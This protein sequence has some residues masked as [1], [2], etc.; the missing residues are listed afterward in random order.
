MTSKE[1]LKISLAHEE[2]DRVPVDLWLTPEVEKRLML[3]TGINDPFE[4]R[5]ALGHDCLITFVGIVASFY[6]SDAKEYV[7][8]WGITWAQASY[9]NGAGSYTEMVSHPLVGEDGRLS[10]YQAPGPADPE[11]YREASCLIEKYGE[12]H[13]IVGG[14]LGSV[15]EGPWYLRG[16]S[17]FL[18]DLLINKDYAHQLMDLVMEFHLKARLKLI[19]PGCDILLAGDDVGAQE[20]MLISSEL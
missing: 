5:I 4:M 2:P 7:C 1:R 18:Q 9:S 15:F 13:C 3:D 12:T 10:S 20:R 14:V 6:R 17:R 8:P 19:N 11:Q 16:M